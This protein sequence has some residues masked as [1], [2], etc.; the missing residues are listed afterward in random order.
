M[1]WEDGEPSGSPINRGGR[2]CIVGGTLAFPPDELLVVDIFLGFWLLLGFGEFVDSW[3]V[4]CM[5]AAW[6]YERGFVIGSGIWSLFA[7]R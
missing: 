5:D 3:A 4:P 7:A 6:E 2:P 1:E